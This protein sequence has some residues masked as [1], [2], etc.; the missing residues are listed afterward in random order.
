MQLI[1]YARTQQ[2]TYTFQCQIQDI[3]T[4]IIDSYIFEYG[5]NFTTTPECL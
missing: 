5:P 1:L 4:I 2:S 3:I